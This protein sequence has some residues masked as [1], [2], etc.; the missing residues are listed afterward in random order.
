MP[1]S[2]AS[3]GAA[4]APADHERAL[5]SPLFF[6]VTAVL[7]GW[8]GAVPATRGSE[9]SSRVKEYELKAAFVFNLSKFVEWP[10]SAFAG[11][12]DAI[13]IGILGE[14][15]FA[16]RLQ[17]TIDGKTVGG[18]R[19]RVR[20]VK[21]DRDARACHIV[22]ISPSEEGRLGQIAERLRG[23]PTLSVSDVGPFAELGGVLHF[24]LEGR[25][26]HLVINPEAATGGG[27]RLS[28]KLLNLARI[29]RDNR[30]GS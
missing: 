13:V 2:S 18:R 28:A 20:Y 12:D 9:D 16:G 29:V 10:A 6:L 23:S 14:D 11:P 19:L 15:P 17:E 5:T 27:L 1:R 25:R 21:A 4:C 26:V 8:L 24:D 3:D 22:F 7:V 30:D